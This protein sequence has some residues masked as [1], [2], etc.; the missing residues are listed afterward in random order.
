ML[1]GIPS[2]SNSASAAD[3]EDVDGA[4]E[5]ISADCQN[6]SIT[7]DSPNVTIDSGVTIDSTAA[8]AVATP[9]ATNA[10]IT[11]NGTI[12]AATNRGFRTSG[13][14]VQELI[15]NGTITAA[16]GR[17]GVRNAGT[18]TTLTNAGTISA[19]INKGINNRSCLLYTSPSPRDGLLSRMP[20]SA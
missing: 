5:T 20:S 1:G 7:G 18:I 19:D 15:N 8:N 13:G 11:N 6:L 16:G 12:S 10:I 3:C 4:T 14:D 2:F 9:D 17:E